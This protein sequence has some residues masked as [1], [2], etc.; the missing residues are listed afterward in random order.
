MFFHV[1]EDRRGS[2]QE[3]TQRT[4]S[5]GTTRYTR[6]T[7]SGL[8]GMIVI[9]EDVKADAQAAGLSVNEIRLECESKLAEAGIPV[10][11]ESQWRLAEGRPWLYV[12]INTIHYL[13][14]YFFSID[15][16]LKQDV[17]LKREPSTGTSAATWE[18]GSIGFVDT[19]HLASKIKESVGNYLDKFIADYAAVNQHS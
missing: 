11:Q 4:M 10:L 2:E 18:M 16:Q 6:E 19:P 5:Q 15:V 3:R 13:T 7:L 17:T 12:S 9:V 14:S 8:P 1:R